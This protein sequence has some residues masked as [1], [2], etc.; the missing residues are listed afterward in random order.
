MIGD[1]FI[2]VQWGG[3][4]GVALLLSDDGAVRD[5]LAF[6]GELAAM[7]RDAIAARVADLRRRWPG[8]PV[9]LSGMV[10]SA[11][12]WVDVP[13]VACPAG[14]AAI[15]AGVRHAR[16]GDADCRILPGLSCRS[17]FGDSDVLRGE[18]VLALGWLRAAP[19]R[20]RALLACVPGRHGKWVAVA[21]GEVRGFHTAMTVELRGLFD[22]RGA[23]A[24]H[25]GADA[26]PDASGTAFTQA[27]ARGAGGGSLARLA[28]GLHVRI[29]EGTLAPGDASAALWGLLIGMDVQ[30]ALPA[31]R[32]PGGARVAV[33][34]A[35]AVAAL[36]RAALVELGHPADMC[37]ADALAGLG[38]AA[39]RDAT[40]KVAR[41]A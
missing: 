29:A 33:V 36:Y 17:A 21:D 40:R 24:R 26:V 18:E 5:R 23:L 15:A 27:V 32:A 22:G 11:G 8:A 35:P 16:I 13:R 3:G 7:G 38:F 19:P 2:G 20:S 6:D 41:A 12:G 39:V 1:G 28:F 37:D 9:W 10:G 4:G 31:W 30:E 14:P 25:L 34:G